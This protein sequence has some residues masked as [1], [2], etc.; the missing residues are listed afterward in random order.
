M[1]L[2]GSVPI[3][4]YLARR[5]VPTTEVGSQFVTNDRK[6]ASSLELMDGHVT[7]LGL[8]YLGKGNSTSHFFKHYDQKFNFRKYKGLLKII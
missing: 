5:L 7:N 6:E 2:G 8:T 4:P 3:W 1:D